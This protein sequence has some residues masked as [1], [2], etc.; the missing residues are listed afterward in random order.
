MIPVDILRSHM[1]ATVEFR[2]SVNVDHAR[3]EN[4]IWTFRI[5]EDA[6][7]IGAYSNRRNDLTIEKAHAA[8][9]ERVSY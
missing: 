2:D 6:I 5:L 4:L 9:Y 3:H 1:K 7:N 8:C